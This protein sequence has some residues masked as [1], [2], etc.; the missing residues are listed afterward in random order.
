MFVMTEEEIFSLWRQGLSKYKVAEIYKR[1]Y[2]REIRL[3]R[4]DM[5]FRHSGRF[6]SHYDALR[7]VE[8][9]ILKRGRT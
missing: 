2:N 5:R 3:I 9:V 4:L 1:R 6:L 7:K 8:E